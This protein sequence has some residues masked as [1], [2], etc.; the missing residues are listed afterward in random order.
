MSRSRINRRTGLLA[1]GV[2]LSARLAVSALAQD[3]VAAVADRGLD[4]L[5]NTPVSTAAKYNQTV[6][7][8]AGSVTIVT[9]E[10]IRRFG[11]RTLTDILRT[12]AGVYTTNPRAYES[13]GIRGFGRPTDYNSRILLLLDGH[14]LFESVW[15]QASLGNEL[16]INLR[17]IERVELI[18]GPSSALYGTGAMFA[19][20][21]LI[22]REGTDIGALQADIEAGSL[23]QQSVALITGSRLGAN[24][25][26]SVSAVYETKDGADDLYFAE[27]DDPATN[28][29]VA[30]K[31]D[32]MERHGLQLSGRLGSF[33]LRG[34]YRWRRQ[35]D[36]TGAYAADFNARQR[37]EDWG[38][39]AELGHVADLSPIHQLTTRVYYDDISYR[40]RYPYAGAIWDDRG[41]NRVAGAEASFRW[42]FAVRH[43]LTVG[44]EYR[45]DIESR[46]FS[47]SEGFSYD[48]PFS[49]LSLYAQEEFQL[50]SNLTL[51]AG[52][53]H[54]N[55]AI[56][57]GATTPRVA[58]L[59]DPWAGTTFKLMYG[60]AFRAP[61]LAEAEFKDS[62]MTGP[63]RPE[64]LTMSEFIWMQRV[65][66]AVL[67]TA[68]V[69][70]YRVKDLIDVVVD[71]ATYENREK[72]RA[73]GAELT[74]DVRP[75][76]AT[77]AY[78]NYTYQHAVSV[79]GS[80]LTNSPRHMVKGGFG[81]ELSRLVTGGL[82]ARYEASRLTVQGT[83][84]D[85]FAVANLNISLH[86]FG[87]PAGSG[88]LM[89]RVEFGFRI[90]NLF[91]SRYAYPAGTEHLQDAIQQDG[92]TFV[93]RVTARL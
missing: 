33:S 26:I 64:R 21:N 40:G 27:Y 61:M 48:R 42:D 14:S 60:A 29:G 10:D 57:G 91:N 55:H 90:E 20:I 38:W 85:P 34:G 59:F 9:A 53:R 62:M 73:E 44:S 71:G 22:P 8:V 86:P 84:T 13:V 4:S 3:S 92:R 5:L 58:L 89:S 28:N 69:F 51:L 37:M 67:L 77:R 54:D 16:A 7:Q 74:L 24:G 83:E 88:S 1:L 2:F 45:R 76:V 39:F 65:N 43:R 75:S 46:Y 49:V 87:K 78:L 17:G 56:S 11:Y 41:R 23:G 72:V 15:G 80:H 79:N 68:S 19:V 36:P 52:V 70:H 6:R 31:M 50:R 12:M 30:H 18:R 47:P 35:D 32:G 82:E 81:A 93:A 63:L 66:R 25:S